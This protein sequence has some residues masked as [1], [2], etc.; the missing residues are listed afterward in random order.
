[1]A[2]SVTQASKFER[3]EILQFGYLA[4]RRAAEPISKVFGDGSRRSLALWQ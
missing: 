3:L 2:F 4:T 1:M